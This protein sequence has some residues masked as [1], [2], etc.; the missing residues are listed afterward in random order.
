MMKL[1]SFAALTF[2]AAADV[3]VFSSND[4]YDEI[5]LNIR[6]LQANVTSAMANATNTFTVS[7]SVTSTYSTT[8]TATALC[9]SV[10]APTC[11]ALTSSTAAGACA[12]TACAPPASRARKLQTDVAIE[13]AYALTFTSQAAASTASET[14]ASPAFATTFAAVLNQELAGGAT[15]LTATV[16][17]VSAPVVVSS[18]TATTALPAAPAPAA[19]APSPS[20]D[21]NTV[22]ANVVLAVASA[23]F[24][25]V[26]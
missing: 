10:S 9:D 15:G 14:I 23:V 25:S 17:S 16:N 21:A 20:S 7:G 24:V 2:V 22:K 12:I 13:Q 6:L 5:N 8:M 11:A 19:A 18:G 26:F 3:P 1:L 4:D